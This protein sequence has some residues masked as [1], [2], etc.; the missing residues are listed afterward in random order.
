MVIWDVGKIAHSGIFLMI[1]S[2]MSYTLT[3]LPVDD[4]PVGL[5]FLQENTQNGLKTLLAYFD[6][7]YCS[8]MWTPLLN[9]SRGELPRRRV[10]RV[11]ASLQAHLHQ[12]CVDSSEGTKTVEEFL[13]GAGHNIRWK[14]HANQVNE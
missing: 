3:L 6:S 8:S 4:L 9:A 14:P 12:L 2:N 5:E 13:W 11:Y 10:K 7:S 1:F